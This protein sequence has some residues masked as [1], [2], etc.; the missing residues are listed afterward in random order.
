MSVREATAAAEALFARAA[1]GKDAQTID[2]R[3]LAAALA[4]LLTEFAQQSQSSR[5]FL[6]FLHGTP[7][8]A[9]LWAKAIVQAADTD[10]DGRLTLAEMTELAERIFCLA[11]RDQDDRLD[12]REIIEALDLLANSSEKIQ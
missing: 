8:V 2:E 11:D 10:V 3:E 1:K 6:S 9:K 5:G 4:P 12:E 7:S